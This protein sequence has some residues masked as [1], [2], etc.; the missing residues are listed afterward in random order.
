MK[1][2]E[3]WQK[4]GKIN[5]EN[6]EFQRNQLLDTLYKTKRYGKYLITTV[7]VFEPWNKIPK[8]LKN[9]LL[10]DLYHNEI[11]MVVSNFYLK[12]Y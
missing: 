7:S 12:S 9:T 4:L 10:K 8:Q 5:L 1:Y 6:P 11:K 2:P 3:K